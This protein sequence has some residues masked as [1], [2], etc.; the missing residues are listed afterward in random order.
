MST[1]PLPPHG[2]TARAKG[3]PAA[4]IKGCPCLPCRDAENRYNKRRRLLNGTG[5]TFMVPA[6]PVADHLRALF[7]AG[8]GWNQ[9]RDVAESSNATISAI[10]HGKVKQIR[11]TTANKFLAI[12]PGDATP[13]GR[14]VPAIGAIRRTRALLAIGH[15]CKAIYGATTV[16]HTQVSE[17]VTGRTDTVAKH[18]HERIAEG[19]AKLAGIP[20][21]SARSRNRAAR[22]GWPPP[23]AW[24]DIDDPACVPDAGRDDAE[25]GRRELAALRR[26][27]ITHLAAYSI[28]EHEIAERLGMAPAYVHDLIRNM[29][30]AA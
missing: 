25:L 12:R 19:Y 17:L 7:A 30:S 21:T 9:L 14:R 4:G 22:E 1:K 27:E 28:P 11:R 26:E 15:T 29:R 16:E 20:G 8:A 24:D 3:R 18:V 6:A 23:A 10:L 13:P 5:R 2:S